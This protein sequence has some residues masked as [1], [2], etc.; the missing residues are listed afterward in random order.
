[1]GATPFTTARLWLAAVVDHRDKAVTEAHL[2]RARAV[3]AQRI[4]ELL[5]L[6]AAG[7]PDRTHTEQRVVAVGAEVL[8][9]TPMHLA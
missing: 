9:E 4:G 8:V 1:M 5:G 6:V 7:V 2:A 3:A